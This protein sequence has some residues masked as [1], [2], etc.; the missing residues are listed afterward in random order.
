[1]ASL[2]GN[3]ASR[4]LRRWHHDQVESLLVIGSTEVNVEEGNVSG[5]R[6]I[7]LGYL[8]L[9]MRLTEQFELDCLPGYLGTQDGQYSREKLKES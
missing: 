9:M 1:M 3:I 5:I 8:N 4:P 2:S 7:A 6:H